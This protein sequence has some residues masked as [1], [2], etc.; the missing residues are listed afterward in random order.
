[1]TDWLPQF[2][3]LSA[4]VLFLLSYQIKHRQGILIANV[5]S[6]ALYILQ[7]F[8]LGAF[9]GAVLDIM[10]V[11]IAL[12][13]SKKNA[14]FVKKHTRAVF[15]SISLFTLLVG[16]AIA[17]RN[18]SLLDILPIIGIQLQSGSFWSSKEKTIRIVSLVGAPFWFVYNFASRAYGSAIGDLLSMVSILI[19]MFKYRSKQAQ[20]HETAASKQEV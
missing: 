6:R 16:G 19:A 18:Q 8:L 14:G 3:G 2:I 11:F 17:I 9:S 10:G 20:N 5:L 7:Y 12:V 13:A 4:V 1:M 15:L